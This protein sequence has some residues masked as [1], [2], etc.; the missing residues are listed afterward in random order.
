MA[1]AERLAELKRHGKDPGRDRQN[2]QKPPS[3]SSVSPDARA[4]PENN[5]IAVVLAEAC[6]GQDI[7]PDELRAMLASED[8]EAIA[9]D[10]I[11][12]ETVR[13]YIP[14]LRNTQR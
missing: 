11:P 7:E 12:M 13:A 1:L 6:K 10:A 4:Y 5:R 2:R 3:V 8:L 14:I 9:S